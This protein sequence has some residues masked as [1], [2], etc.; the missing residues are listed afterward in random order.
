MR[1]RVLLSVCLCGL[2]AALAVSC[3]RQPRLSDEAY[4][5][6]VTA[7]HTALAALQTSQD[8]LAR[9][10]LERVITLAPHEPAPYANLGLMLLRQ[11]QIEE[12]LQR[13]GQASERAPDHAAIERLLALAESARGN[14]EAAIGRWRRAAGLDPA[15]LKAPFALALE[16]ERQGGPG[17]E[18]EA[19]QIL[20]AV[21]DRSGNLAARLEHARLA[22]KRGDAPA[23]Q[24]SLDALSAMSAGWPPD[25]RQRLQT[26]REAAARGPAEA[27]TPVIF[28]KNVLI[29]EP[30]YR[31]DLAEVTTPRSEVGEPLTRFLV[32]RNPEPQPAPPDGQIV[33]TVQPQPLLPLA[34]AAWAAPIWLTGEGAPAIAAAG[35]GEVRVSNGAVVPFPG[36]SAATPPGPF[37]VAL[38]DVNY[39]FRTDLVVAGAGGLR[40]FH[41]DE[42]GGFA[43]RTAPA[44]LPIEITGAAYAG[45]WPADV[46]TDGDLDLVA[47]TREGT[48]A[49][50]R[51][52]GDGTFA[53]QTPFAGVS[54]LRG[55]VWADLDGEGVPDAALVDAAGAVR[56]FLNLRGGQFRERAVP[57]GFSGLV[58]VAAADLSGDAVLD[59]LGVTADGRLLRL[60]QSPSRD[61]WE[62]ADAGRVDLPSG[63]SPETGRLLVHDLDNNG[64]G[65]VVVA[66]ASAARVLL[67]GAGAALRPAGGEV[68]LGAAGAADLDGDGRL[69]LIG[70]A[71]GGARVARSSGQKA[72]HWQIIRP[73]ASAA[74]GDQRINSFGIGGEVEVRTGLHAQ[75]QVIGAPAVH[76]GLGSAPRA[77][78][79]RI[80]WPNGV[81][82][83]EF[84]LRADGTVTATQRLKGSCPWLFAWNGRAME[85]VTDFIWRSPLGLRINAQDA[86]DVLM[87]EDWVRI[88]GDQLAPKDGAYDL[89]I[90]A[91]LW[92]THFFDLVSLLVVD[93]P[94]G[95]EV[96]VDERFAVPPPPPGVVATSPVAPFASVLDDRGRDVRAVVE[97]RDD[98]HLDFAGRGAYQGVTRPHYIELELPE[99]A[100][101]SGALWLVGQGWVHPTDSSINVALGQGSH[102]PPSGLSI[103]VADR[104]GRFREVRGGLGFPSGKDKTILIDLA[105]LFPS[106]GPRRFRLQT[107][108]EIFW[109]RLGWAAGRP[110][111]RLEP[112]RLDL[113]SADLRFRG[114]SPIVQHA[115]RPE[116]PRYAIE[117]T[118]ARWRDLEG[119]YTRFG[120][121]RELLAKVDDR[122]VIM[123]AAD[124][125][126]LT[127]PEAPPPAA[128]MVRDFVLIGDGWVK[129]GDFN[130]TASRTVLPLPTHASAAY[131][132]GGGRLEED[133]VYRRHRDDFERYHTRYVSPER[134]REALRVRI[135]SR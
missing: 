65:D 112:R 35:S 116:R 25:A 109:D 124:E 115:S 55:F 130:T 47:G 135:E 68:A 110:D 31:A 129:D 1:T 28:L 89:R 69:E 85:F 80:V 58:A 122:Y 53:V 45:V 106:G 126:R 119:F 94:A 26:L 74:T 13:L 19:Q 15:D 117:G 22:A 131:A 56:T 21:A 121:V 33:F 4:L 40:L 133:P 97:A 16:L 103:H 38:A 118:A 127:F 30:V 50:L 32:L 59:L 73:R 48:P 3:R 52:N 14:V 84:D 79:A 108:M 34:G 39:D 111:V 49:V 60:S 70:A 17:A 44:R 10:S 105:G 23:L 99:H 37:G 98:R 7:F 41:Q 107:N 81:L 123:N 87:T 2:A 76:F 83:S 113:A 134:L 82:Q 12:A 9:Q 6:A 91:E 71:P 67:A 93:H 102:P 51:N 78:V 86:A 100:P 104:H 8:V 61:G 72:Y 57:D 101:R 128:G 42:K 54:R 114:Y 63:F 46:D 62:V 5:E 11:Q 18:Q 43:D 125:I 66:G 29:R 75:K 77:E 88:R 20:K 24:A 120:D 132:P 96:F 27:A 36:G 90:T 92:E 95:T 64:A